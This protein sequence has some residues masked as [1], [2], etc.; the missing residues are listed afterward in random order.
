[1]KRIITVLIVAITGILALSGCVS[2]AETTVKESEVLKKDTIRVG[3]ELEYKPFETIDENGEPYG[4]SVAY[5]YELG[6]SLGKKVEIIPTKY[7][8]LIPS[9]ESGKIDMIIS[10]MTITEERQ[11]K[12]DFSV[13]YAKSALY[14]LASEK[15]PVSDLNS[16]NKE[17]VTIAVKT[18][19]IA[20]VWAQQNA[21]Q[22]KI[23][24]FDSI[25]AAVLD[26]SNNQSDVTIYDP[27]SIY[28]YQEQYPK[29]RIL[30]EPITNTNGWG[31]AL[32]KGDTQLKE[33]VDA[34]VTTS[35]TDGTIDRLKQ[36]YLTEEIEKFSKYEIPFFI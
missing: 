32:P 29:T 10:S 5:A 20:A 30:E 15:S 36:E 14:V 24:S 9:L 31:I 27:L 23:K 3:M 6:K 22:A 34:F 17:E 12:V 18:G 33:K 2:Q 7:D 26:V 13:E 4:F 28:E 8:A 19:T 1:M 21:P 16:L 11:K 35:K 25:D